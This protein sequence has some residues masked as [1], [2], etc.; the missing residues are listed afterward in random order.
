MPFV[1][2]TPEGQVSLMDLPLEALDRI[3]S[4]TDQRWIE[5]I[6]APASSAKVALA[7]YAEACAHVDAKPEQLTPAR[8]VGDSPIFEMV[9]DDLPDAFEG[10]IP[11]S[12]D[13]RET[14]GSSGAPK[15]STGRPTSPDDSRSATSDS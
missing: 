8:L 14:T 7:V 11:K 1:V 10:G 5:I 4:A 12:E 6:I 15:S 13:G 2:N 3:E 9:D